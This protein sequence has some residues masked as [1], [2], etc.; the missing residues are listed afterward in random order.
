MEKLPIDALLAGVVTFAAGAVL[1][2]LRQR[3]RRPRPFDLWEF[4]IVPA[5]V[6]AVLLWADWAIDIDPEY[7]LGAWLI[8]LAV[9]AG[10]A[11]PLGPLAWLVWLIVTVYS[12]RYSATALDLIGAV[13]IGMLAGGIAGYAVAVWHRRIAAG[14]GYR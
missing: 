14:R 12:L 5:V 6:L 10:I 13:C 2:F 1:T 11:L 7:V 4:A 9:L 3:K 8:L